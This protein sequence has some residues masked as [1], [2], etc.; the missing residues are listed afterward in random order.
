MGHLCD[1]IIFDNWFMWTRHLALDAEPETWNDLHINIEVRRLTPVVIV[2]VMACLEDS[3]IENR[4][5]LSS[6]S[7]Y[8]GHAK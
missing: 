8:S 4:R 3:M 2:G 5:H 1:S 7:I 6:D